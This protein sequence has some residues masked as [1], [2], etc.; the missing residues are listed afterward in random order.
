MKHYEDKKIKMGSEGKMRG[1]RKIRNGRFTQSFLNKYCI[2][3]APG[4]Q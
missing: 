4:F 3:I 1:R 2:Y